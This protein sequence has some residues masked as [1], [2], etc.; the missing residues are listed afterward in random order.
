MYFNYNSFNRLN[1]FNQLFFFIIISFFLGEV[2]QFFL[3][4]FYGKGIFKLDFTNY[5][6]FLEIIFEVIILAPLIE[7]FFIQFTIIELLLKFFSRKKQIHL[8]SIIISASFF[9]ILHQYNIAYIIAT[10]V[11]GLWFGS[12]YIFYKKSK[13]INSFLALFLVHLVYNSINLIKDYYL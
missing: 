7:T 11:L 10:F 3:E 1:I 4:Y 8:Y 6:S 5:S 12:I 2:L 13:K 9:G